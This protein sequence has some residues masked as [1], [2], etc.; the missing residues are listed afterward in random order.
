MSTPHVAGA[1]ALLK[2]RHPLWTVEQVKSA[3]ESTG[4][5]V[6]VP[7]TGTEVATTREGGGRIDLA[8]ADNP[9]VFTD[10]AN[11]SWG[12]VRPGFVGTKALI[13]TDAGGG[14]D[15][16]SVS[17]AVQSAPLGA[18][19]SPSAPTVVPG[20]QI[21]VTLTVP[22]STLEGEATGFLLLQRG[23][24]VRRVPFWFH[25]ER[26]RLALDRHT[27]L[28]RPG[29]Y[30]GD[31]AG[32]AARVSFYRYPDRAV[33]AGVPTGLAGPEQV[34]RFTLTKTVANFGVV[35][36]T[37]D[38]GVRVSPRLVHAGDENRLVG[39]TGLPVT[40]NPYVG[41]PQPYPV[42]GAV[43]PLPGAY[44]IV[45]DTPAGARPGGFLFRLWVN[46]TT[47]PAVKLLGSSVRAGEPIR[48][49]V[50]DSGAGVDPNSLV[51]YRDGTQV[52]LSYAHGVVSLETATLAQGRHRITLDASDY[53]ETKNME[54]IG[55]VLPNTR[56]FHATVTVHP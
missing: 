19:I 33:T 2:Q 38:K 35:V 55:P 32:K 20:T 50:R 4:D 34:F 44:D 40:L 51:A 54:D 39:A 7:G 6:H 14:V 52:P 15:P 17:V 22:T 3:L 11:L 36:L 25:V 37:H 8:R 30:R 9:L 1:A 27:T 26:P 13:V 29:L 12:L 48:L 28:T 24:D 23:A 43:L 56:V 10:P 45:F 31:T 5:P 41:V 42:V 53:Q 49:S 21:G 18:T 47:P 16:W 46:D